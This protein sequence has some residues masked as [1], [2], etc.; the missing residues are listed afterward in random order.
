MVT[1]F[2]EGKRYALGGML[3]CLLIYN[4]KFGSLWRFENGLARTELKWTGLARDI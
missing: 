2:L 4:V 3:L 1:I